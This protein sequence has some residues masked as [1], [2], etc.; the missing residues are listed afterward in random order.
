MAIINCPECNKEISDKSKTC[1]NCG[2]PLRD[3]N[4][5]YDKV[6]KKIKLSSLGIVVLT[7]VITLI[8]GALS[9]ENNEEIGDKTSTTS[10]AKSIEKDAK[11]D[12][13]KDAKKENDIEKEDV[14]YEDTDIPNL[15]SIKK[16]EFVSTDKVDFAIKNINI[17]KSI[18]APG[19]E[20]CSCDYFDAEDG[21]VYI[22][23]VMDIINSS[24]KKIRQDSVLK[25]AIVYHDNKD[26]YECAAVVADGDCNFISDTDKY[27]IA[28][29]E[30]LEYHMLAQVPNKVK[31]S[32]KSLKGYIFVDDKIYECVL[33][34]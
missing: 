18:R 17:A 9:K 14:S 34:K 16:G 32:N 26:D 23:I 7:V 33:R 12:T 11:K 29:T 6:P 22:D 31:K 8:I 30:K 27:S 15:I 24:T 5:M 28:P 1:V 10:Y 19:C 4:R 25:G 3:R 13:E 20:T 2:Y 21:K